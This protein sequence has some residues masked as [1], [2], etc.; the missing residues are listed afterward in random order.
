M[1]RPI[2]VDG[3]NVFSPEAARAAGFDYACIGRPQPQTA[4]K[5]AEPIV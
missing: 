4:K 3:R 1:S 2:L 5:M